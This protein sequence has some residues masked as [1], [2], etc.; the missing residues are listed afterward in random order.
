VP[1]IHNLRNTDVAVGIDDVACMAL[2]R[3]FNEPVGRSYLE[4]R[5]VDPALVSQLDLM[6]ISS[7]A[8]M[9]ICVKVAKYFELTERD[10][11]VTVATDS[12]ELYGSRFEEERALHG[13]YTETLG[14][15]HHERHLLGAGIDHL[16]ELSYWDRKRMHNLKYFTWVEQLGKSVEELDAQ[17][18]DPTYWTS[19]WATW[20]DLDQRIREFNDR[21]GLLNK[22]S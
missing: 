12:M 5:G 6:G 1:W 8:N 19:K 14:A 4:S 17:W 18:E 11:L 7:I 15:V 2:L 3:L 10:V 22:Y 13:E 16:L 20:K 21:T 9:L